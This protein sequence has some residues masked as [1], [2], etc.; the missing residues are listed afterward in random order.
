M[1]RS[2]KIYW[3]SG[4]SCLRERTLQDCDR[5]TNNFLASE[6]PFSN[7]LQWGCYTRPSLCVSNKNTAKV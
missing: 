5:N 2:P 3:W 1:V 4:R 7:P 6:I